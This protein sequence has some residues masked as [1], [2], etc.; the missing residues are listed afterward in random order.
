MIRRFNYT[1]RKKIPRSSVRIQIHKE[2]QRRRFEAELALGDLQLPKEARLYIEA[3][4]RAAY[5]R[6]NFGTV[7]DP[8]SPSERWLDSIPIGKPLFRVKVVVV[9]DGL[10]RIIAA[11]DRIVPDDTT[12][13]EDSRQSLLP[14]EYA[15]LGDRVWALELDADWPCLLLNKRFE[16]IRE[17]AR[18]G[19]EFLTLV[20]PEVFRAILARALQEG[21]FDPDCDDD[22]WGTLWLRFACRELQR[23]RPPEGPDSQHNDWIEGAVNAL[24]VRFQTASL[25]Q[26]L[27]TG[28]DTG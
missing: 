28:Q 21:R 12:L 14:V 3:Y 8:R 26:R 7:G 15:D 10:S 19:P 24:C 5:Q 22:D 13:K 25:F 27:L 1:G 23:P 18:S 4:Y 9:M 17:A 20:Y 6:F 2:G 16:G 11:A